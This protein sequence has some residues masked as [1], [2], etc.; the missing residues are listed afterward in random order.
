MAVK[1]RK[2]LKEQNK[3]IRIVIPREVGYVSLKLRVGLVTRDRGWSY[4]PSMT[5]IALT[6]FFS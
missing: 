6:A 1:Q 5:L 4:Q 3:K 2:S